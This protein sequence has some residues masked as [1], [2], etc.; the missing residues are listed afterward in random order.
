MIRRWQRTN[1]DWTIDTASG[2]QK[3]I[4]LIEQKTGLTMMRAPA[5]IWSALPRHKKMKLPEF[6]EDLRRIGTILITGGLLHA[7]IDENATIT[8][9]ILLLTFGA[10][11][12]AIGY[13]EDWKMNNEN[14]IVAYIVVFGLMIIIYAVTKYTNNKKSDQE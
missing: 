3:E 2:E 9:I 11:L 7:G 4:T 5:E 1:I 13:T 14:L 8:S 10:I 12:M 6:K